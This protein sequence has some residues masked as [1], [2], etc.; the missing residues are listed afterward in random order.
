MTVPQS[1]LQRWQALRSYKY[2]VLG[3]ATLGTF[4]TTLDVSIVAITL[5]ELEEAM[6][7]NT[8]TILWVATT[9]LLTSLSLMLVAGRLSDVVGRKRWFVAGTL[10]FTVGLGISASSQNVPQLIFSRAVTA[11]GAAMLL[12]S[13][14]ALITSAFPRSER[15]RVMGVLGIMISLGLTIGPLTGGPLIDALGWRAVF[16]VRI[17]LGFATALGA[18]L[19]LR[20]SRSEDR[21]WRF[22]YAGA[23]TISVGLF[24]VVFA[25]SRAATWGLTSP[26]F[27]ACIMSGTASLALFARVET[28]A[29][30]PLFDLALLRHRTFLSA[31]ASAL[32]YFMAAGAAFFLTPFYLTQGRGESSS[33]TGVIF[34]VLTVGILILAPISGVLSDRWGSRWPVVSGMCVWV[35]SLLF[36]GSLGEQ[37]ALGIVVLALFVAGSGSGLAEVSNN[38]AI[39]GSAPEA[40]LGTAAAA[41]AISR[42]LG[43]SM[44]ISVGGA[45]FASRQRLYEVTQTDASA[46]VNAYQD[47]MM[48]MIGVMVVAA[49]FAWLRRGG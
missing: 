14:L 11:V 17:P 4:L 22:D 42:Q 20:E 47:V 30:S 12:S 49:M 26:V 43:L 15:G 32:F 41:V 35:G 29:A 46:V 9:Y 37:T 44:G 10:L 19:L 8:P 48:I 39:M 1:F 28:R 33:M 6:N 34:A 45:I 18:W 36:L 16:Y 31:T 38:S 23:A 40:R 13:A 21:N 7:T 24:L 5:P 3:V 27:L 25:I 2:A